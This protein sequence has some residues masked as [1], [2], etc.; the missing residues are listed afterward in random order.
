MRP[1][2][3]KKRKNAYFSMFKVRNVKMRYKQSETKIKT[4]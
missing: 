2:L 3:R 1:Q 4:Y